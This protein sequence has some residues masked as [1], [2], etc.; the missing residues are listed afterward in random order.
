MWLCL[1]RQQCWAWLVEADEDAVVYEITFNLPDAGLCKNI[2]PS[3]IT[4]TPTTLFSSTMSD[5][6][7]TTATRQ[8]PSQS[9]RSVIGHQHQPKPITQ[10]QLKP[11]TQHQPE[12]ITPRVPFAHYTRARAPRTAFLQLGKVWTHRGAL[13]VGTLKD[14]YIRNVPLPRTPRIQSASHVTNQRHAD[15]CYSQES[16]VPMW[17]N[18]VRSLAGLGSNMLPFSPVWL[19]Q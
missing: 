15:T 19:M 13:D 12:P 16:C 1:R 10:H 2:V 14:G 18:L 3:D 6:N 17:S 7:A 4:A 8:Y 5:N 9:C 11:I